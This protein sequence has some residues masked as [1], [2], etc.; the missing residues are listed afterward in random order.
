[1]PIKLISNQ[2]IFQVG[3][4]DQ[5]F[6]LDPATGKQW[7]MWKTDHMINPRYDNSQYY[8]SNLNDSRRVTIWPYDQPK[9][10]IVNIIKNN[11][12]QGVCGGCRSYHCYS[13][14]AKKQ[15]I[16]TR[17]SEVVIQE[18]N[19]DGVSFVEGSSPTVKNI[20][21][22]INPHYSQTQSTF[23]SILMFRQSL[24]MT[25]NIFLKN[26]GLW[27]GCGWCLGKIHYQLSS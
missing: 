15:T 5:H 22:I 24:V 3:P 18:L 19:E 12:N 23:K 9:V 14:P 16:K 17:V 27:R 1:M 10:D 4:I 2:A 7:L 21:L 8:P 26:I 13:H 11:Q 25:M 20:I 6:F